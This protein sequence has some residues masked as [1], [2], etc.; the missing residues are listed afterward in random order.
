MKLRITAIALDTIAVSKGHD[1][2]L[3]KQLFKTPQ[4]KKTIIQLLVPFS[5]GMKYAAGRVATDRY[6]DRHTMQVS[7]TPKDVNHEQ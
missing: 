7:R 1:K 3:N 2:I 5:H 6:T 4:I